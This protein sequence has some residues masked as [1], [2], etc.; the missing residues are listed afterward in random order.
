M[1]DHPTDQPPPP[2]PHFGTDEEMLAWA[3]EENIAPVRDQEG[4][5]D[6]HAAW[7]TYLQRHTS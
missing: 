4:N 1:T 7:E 5:Y 2:D 6:W 3:Q